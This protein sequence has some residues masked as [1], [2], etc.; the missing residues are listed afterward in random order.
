MLDWVGCYLRS[1]LPQALNRLLLTDVISFCLAFAKFIEPSVFSRPTIP[2]DET[3]TALLVH[4]NVGGSDVS[5]TFTCHSCKSSCCG[6]QLMEE[7]VDFS[8]C[9]GPIGMPSTINF[10]TEDQIVTIVRQLG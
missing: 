4:K 10:H 6:Q 1:S 9:I 8:L 5:K 7:I 3:D 2:I